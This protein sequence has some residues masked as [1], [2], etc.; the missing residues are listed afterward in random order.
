MSGFDWLVCPHCGQALRLVERVAGCQQ[1]HRF[2][3]ARQGYL[4]LMTQAAGANADT[5]EMVARRV[6]FLAS[7]HY[8]PIV[9]AVAA[10][11]RTVAPRR[12]LDVG[13]GPGY[14]LARVLDQLASDG[15]PAEGLGLDI[16]T[17]AAKRL[18]KCH[19]QV[20]A[21][22]ADAWQPWPVAQ[23]SVQAVL[24]IFAPRNVAECDRVLTEKGVV[25]TVTPLPDHLAQAREQFGLMGIQPD[26][27]E[28]LSETMAPLFVAADRQ[29]VR[30]DLEL[31]PEQVAAV[32][33][34][35]PNALHGAQTNG[36]L[37]TTAAVAVIRW[38]RA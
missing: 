19:P 11:V 4:N 3:L 1:G 14:Y 35:G 21:V 22:V 27:E 12:L 8:Q 31:S 37:H 18:A 38:E 36:S 25:V 26:K 6:E 13:A 2:D 16:S 28:R 5:A 34:M 32:V 9:D 7:G 33:G 17:A 30:L 24:S 29:E 20:A 15:V 23:T 10:A